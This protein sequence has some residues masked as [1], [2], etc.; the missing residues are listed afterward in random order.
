MTT[1][2]IIVLVILLLGG[3]SGYHCYS[4]YGAPGRRSR[5]GIDRYHRALAGRWRAGLIRPPGYRFGRKPYDWRRPGM[6]VS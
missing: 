1:I 2:L 4:R 5:S 6:L 3:F